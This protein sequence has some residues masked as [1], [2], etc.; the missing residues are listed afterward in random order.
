M[1]DADM[2]LANTITT[3]SATV[4][5]LAS[6]QPWVVVNPGG[7]VVMAAEESWVRVRSGERVGSYRHWVP[8]AVR[9]ICVFAAVL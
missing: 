8:H 1:A 7:T 4:D 6:M 5:K 9:V 3:M 2:R